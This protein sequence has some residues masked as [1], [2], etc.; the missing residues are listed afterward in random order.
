M[1]DWYY[2]IFSQTNKVIGY[3]MYFNAAICP[4]MRREH[5]QTLPNHLHSPQNHKPF[6]VVIVNHLE[7]TPFWYQCIASYNEQHNTEKLAT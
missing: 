5:R 1:E 7:Y 4:Y 2:S 3:T 6:N